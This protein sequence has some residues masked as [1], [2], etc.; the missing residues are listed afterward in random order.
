MQRA[1]AIALGTLTI[2]I[3]GICG[4]SAEADQPKGKSAS[5]KADEKNSHASNPTDNAA[6]GA[7]NAFGLDLY[8][9]IARDATDRNIFISPYS[10]SVALTMAAEGARGETETE[11]ANVLQFPVRALGGRGRR[12]TIVHQ[13]YAALRQRFAEAA[14]SAND[15]TRKRI[16]VLR[17]K[18]D[19]AN[20]E[21]EAMER[22]SD[23]RAAERS[24]KKAQKIADALN[25]LLTQVDRFDLRSANALW[26]DQHFP[27]LGSYVETIDRFYESGGVTPLDIRGDTE[28][29]RLRINGWVEDNTEK[30]I[31]D[32]IPKGDLSSDTGLV[33]T[34]AIYFL[35]QWS[36]PFNKDDTRDE[37]F[38]LA[39]GETQKVK[40]MQD[41][42]R[43]GVPYA[44]FN[45]DG[46]CFETPAKVPAREPGDETPG[47]QTYPDEG[48]FTM[49]ELPYKG[50]DLT[51]TLIAPRT[52]TGLASIEAKL[53]AESLGAWLAKLDARQVHVAMPRFKLEA[54]YSMGVTLQ[55][56]G[57]K[58]AFTSPAIPDGA[59]FSGMSSSD[60][61]R[62]Q[63][64]IGAVLHKA[65]VEVN[66][67][68]TEAAA[69][70]AV[71]M[72]VGSAAPR[73]EMIPFIPEFRADRPFL[74]L[75]RDT[76]TGVILFIGRMM[77]PGAA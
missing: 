43:K 21:A 5:M 42:W 17:K 73:V 49:I 2:A 22:G 3:A 27:L 20:R 61:P 26:V 58:R 69:A 74:F 62:E 37:D 1:I 31:K 35:G 36:E 9:A 48:G 13:G 51:M 8:R 59:D 47:P 14:G 56:M 60:D 23:W 4:L 54:D 44:A 11:M 25:P 28:R 75:I 19:D 68:G 38:T 70:T 15:A 16:E 45:G 66:E 67:E 65:F 33:I 32:L 7:N 40:M 29:S 12:V 57:M 30:R 53:D 46:S 24:Q 77:H 76:K 71:L 18:L 63:L 39:D 6:V 64:F 72:R 52:A 41:R 10:M 55:A 50:D 34:N